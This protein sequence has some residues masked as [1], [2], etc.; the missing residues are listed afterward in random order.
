MIVN[1][2]RKHVPASVR[3]K[4]YAL[5]LGRVLGWLRKARSRTVG[6][7]AWLVS[8][9]CPDNEKIAAYAFI[10]RHGVTAYPGAYSLKY[11]NLPVEVRRD[12]ATGMP[13][14]SH[15]G[16]RLYF[17][18]AFTDERV[19][20]LYRDLLTEQDEG[21]PHRYQVSYEGLRGA[22]V[23][24]MG[25]AE[26]IFS[27]GLVDL[28]ERLYLFECDPD[29]VPALEATFAPWKEKVRIIR[30]FVGG[31][32]GEGFVTIDT[33]LRE[34][35]R[36]ERLFLKMDIEGAEMDALRGARQTLE[37]YR[38]RLGFSI[39][40][41]HKKDDISEIPALLSAEGYDFER[42]DGYIYVWWQYAM[43]RGLVRHI[44]S[45]A[46]EQTKTSA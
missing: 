41:Y 3:D 19:R 39:C 26:G 42:T 29:W 15:E 46:E 6:I 31:T 28:A 14:V 36:P 12:P 32:D 24:D 1:W 4:I 43:R 5:F 17:P 27:L 7:A 23:L 8:P 34:I 33:F 40:T 45:W 38:G 13:Y 37:T 2:Y 18:A 16:R 25:A 11:E 10:G 21:S 30:K 44:E 35:P 20:D 9:L 22:T